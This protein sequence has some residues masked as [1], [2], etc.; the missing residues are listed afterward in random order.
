[1]KL[2]T[3]II[4]TLA[5]FLTG[6]LN[7]ESI[8]IYDSFVNVAASGFTFVPQTVGFG[9]THGALI[10][11][12]NPMG[13]PGGFRIWSASD[14]NNSRADA[15][16]EVPTAL[17][18]AFRISFNAINQ[19]YFWID[20]G[21]RKIA[22]RGSNPGTVEIINSSSANYQNLIEVMADGTVS[23]AWNW[24]NEYPRGTSGVAPPRYVADIGGGV[25]VEELPAGF[26]MTTHLYDLIVNASTTADF[27]YV[28]HGM[29]RTLHPL[30]M[31]LFVDGNLATPPQ[32]PN[33]TVFENKSSFVLEEGFGVFSFTT[34]TQSHAETDFVLDQIYIHTG[35]AISEGEVEDSSPLSALL[36]NST[37]VSGGWYDN[38]TFGLFWSNGSSSAIYT[39][40]GW[41]V[42]GAETD[43]N[44]Y[45]YWPELDAWTY[46]PVAASGYLYV[47]GDGWKFWS[48]EGLV[49]LGN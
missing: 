33:G 45:A 42:L 34:A 6:P 32:N 26:E 21:L 1:M 7:A 47:Y 4:L 36:E 14:L 19:N 12:E 46:L 48:A 31:D 9:S 40:L 18:G 27:T 2:K 41:A 5:G 10:T 23:G 24:N 11:P 30:R 3:S 49:A 37:T 25:P 44:F 20:S 29:S 39:P 22:L 8:S 38:A 16:I 17:T 43:G 35:D 13:H 28:L 15:S